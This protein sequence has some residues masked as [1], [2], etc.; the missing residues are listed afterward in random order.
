MYYE[1]AYREQVPS[2]KPTYKGLKPAADVHEV[3]KLLAQ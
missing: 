2:N 1:V 3:L